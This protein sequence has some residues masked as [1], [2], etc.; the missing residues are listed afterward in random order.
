MIIT[1]RQNQDT[2]VKPRW[3][4]SVGAMEGIVA[5]NC[6]KHGFPRPALAMPIWEGAGSKAVDFSG[7][8]RHGVITSAKWQKN[9]L[10]LDGTGNKVELNYN[11]IVESN[12][13]TVFALC[14]LDS[15]PYFTPSI[16]AW[17]DSVASGNVWRVTVDS[18]TSQLRT[19]VH[20]GYIRGTTNVADGKL[21]CLA[22]AF[23]GTDVSTGT[24]LYVDG[25]L[26]SVS[27]S[28]A[29]TVDTQATNTVK[30]GIDESATTKFLQAFIKLIYIFDVK[31]F[32]PQIKFLSDHPYF[33]FRIPEQLY[34]K[35]AAAAGVSIPVF[36]HYY[37]QLLRG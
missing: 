31:L 22:S 10:Y 23:S 32:A 6:R 28:A 9:S 36:M 3:Q 21:H 34:G 15:F 20:N 33:M 7:Y 30:L 29:R 13:R 1:P 19:E 18:T 12:D 27:G 37:R 26:E 8:G 35:A 5:H 17:G 14:S 11:G 4:L 2:Q 16:I 25:V 24:D